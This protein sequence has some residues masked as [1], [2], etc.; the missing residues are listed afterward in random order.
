VCLVNALHAGESLARPSLVFRGVAEV[1]RCSV[2]LPPLTIFLPSN[3]RQNGRTFLP[4]L[5]LVVVRYGGVRDQ[6]L[7]D[8]RGRA[9]CVHVSNGDRVRW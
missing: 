8:G 6:P 4:R 1:A 7:D 3:C 5:W 2:L 9:L